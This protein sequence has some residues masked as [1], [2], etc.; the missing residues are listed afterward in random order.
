MLLRPRP[1][2]GRREPRPL[3]PPPRTTGHSELYLSRVLGKPPRPSRSL[4]TRPSTCRPTAS[5]PGALTGGA[6]ARALARA[7]SRLCPWDS[8]DRERSPRASCPGNNTESRADDT[9]RVTDEPLHPVRRV[10]HARLRDRESPGWAVATG[11]PDSPAA[12]AQTRLPWLRERSD[13]RPCTTSSLRRAV[14]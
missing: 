11:S 4:T 5:A 2:Y 9:W 1:H 3:S 7:G 12:S 13:R 10:A 14:C 8:R 6:T